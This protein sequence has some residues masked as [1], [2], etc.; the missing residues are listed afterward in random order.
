M[1][2]AGTVGISSLLIAQ[3]IDPKIF[4]KHIKVVA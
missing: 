2:I 4:E 1:D 3:P